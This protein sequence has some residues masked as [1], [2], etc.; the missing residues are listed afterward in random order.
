MSMMDYGAVRQ[1]FVDSQPN[2]ATKKTF[3]I[4]DDAYSKASAVL[5]RTL[6]LGDPIDTGPS[7]ALTQTDW[8][9]GFGQNTFSDESMFYESNMDTTSPLG[10]ARPWEGYNA[11]VKGATDSTAYYSAIYT[12]GGLDPT[13]PVLILGG[14]G[15]TV[16]TVDAA[17]TVT[18]RNGGASI[19][20][21]I[22]CIG[23]M[24]ETGAGTSSKV[25]MGTSTGKLYQVDINTWTFTDI[26]HPSITGQPISSVATYNG[27]L[28]VLMGNVLYTRDSGATWTVRYTFN[29]D[30]TGFKLVVSGN[31]V[32]I[33][34]GGYG[35]YVKAYVSDT[36]TTTL[37]YTWKA[38]WGADAIAYNGV[39]Y[40]YIKNYKYDVAG[41][42]TANPSLYQYNGQSMRLL[43]DR[44]DEDI[45]T[46]ESSQVDVSLCMYKNMIAFSYTGGTAIHGTMVGG[47][48]LGF[49]LY[50]PVKDA[51]HYGPSVG[52]TGDIT[53]TSMAAYGN[54]VAFAVKTNTTAGGTGYRHV[55]RTNSAKVIEDTGFSGIAGGS[56]SSVHNRNK[57][58]FIRS[59]TFDS[60]LPFQDKVWMSLT[61][62]F[63][64]ESTSF[65]YQIDYFTDAGYCELTP[66]GSVVTNGAA[67]NSEG[68]C[69]FS[70]Y[71][72]NF[73]SW[74]KSKRFSYS[75]ILKQNSGNIDSYKIQSLSLKYLVAPTALKVWRVRVLCSDGQETLGGTA[76]S[77][78]TAEAQASYLYDLWAAGTPFYW[79]EPTVSDTG[80]GNSNTIVIITDYLESSFRVDTETGEVVKEVSLTL[81]Q[82]A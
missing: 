47:G 46:G 15:G 22:N 29:E 51:L 72:D 3:L 27:K 41:T 4:R 62:T 49:M 28:V 2:G 36:T 54:G 66:V 55:L 61:S 53:I 78:T 18:S 58:H 77:L 12:V 10:F 74:P 5:G 31:T 82:V 8:S 9:G 81:Y 13:A 7:S 56:L 69:F 73:T 39:V 17:G 24:A 50:D 57:K 20:G 11:F 16:S 75:M 21:V 19:G 37:L 68:D 64:V 59:S 67:G 1:I 30:T 63:F 65:D 43:H 34:V 52:P 14:S 40:F 33:L 80:F 71:P 48:I 70:T 45:W 35:P 23:P 26:S 32:Y 60:N 44:S 38:A 6:R 79:W 76:N 42:A 25:V